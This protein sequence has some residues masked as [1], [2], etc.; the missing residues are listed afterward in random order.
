MLAANLGENVYAETI[1]RPGPTAEHVLRLFKCV[2]EDEILLVY[3]TNV[4]GQDVFVAYFF[5]DS[6]LVMARYVLAES[7]RI[8]N[9]L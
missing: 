3:K 6:Q 4:I 9:G 7:P 5:I 1:Y 2:E 8:H